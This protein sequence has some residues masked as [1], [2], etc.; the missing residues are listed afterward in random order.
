MNV[1]VSRHSV[2]PDHDWLEDD[3]L[4]ARG[5]HRRVS[6]DVYPHVFIRRE[7]DDNVDFYTHKIT[8]RH[9][10]D[11]LDSPSVRT[12]EVRDGAQRRRQQQYP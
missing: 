11:P 10:P 12:G 2:T 4:D 5:D 1:L 3:S 8:N 6:D 9:L 7:D